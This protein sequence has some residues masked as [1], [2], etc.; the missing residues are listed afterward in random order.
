[1]ENPREV[2]LKYKNPGV[3]CRITNK[4]SLEIQGEGVI[5]R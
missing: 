3:E 1:M 2:V 4:N 5:K